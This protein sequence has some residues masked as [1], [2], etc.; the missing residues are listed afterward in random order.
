M[1]LIRKNDVVQSTLKKNEDTEREKK[2]SWLFLVHHNN[3]NK[4]VHFIKLKSQIYTQLYHQDVVQVYEYLHY[5][6]LQKHM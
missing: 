5:Q 1:D 3:N 4:K 2:K 6:F